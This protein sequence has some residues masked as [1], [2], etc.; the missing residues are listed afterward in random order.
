M[1]GFVKL[2]IIVV[3]SVV[4]GCGD[5]T[6]ETDNK[7]VFIEDGACY[8]ETER[9]KRDFDKG[10]LVYTFY[11]VDEYAHNDRLKAALLKYNID[12]MPLGENCLADSNCYGKYMYSKIV[13]KYGVDFIDS[14]KREINSSSD[15]TSMAN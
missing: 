4:M 3:L 14:L 6:I 9:A 12:Y 5:S 10:I 13:E 8:M 1:K 15:D 7:W 11:S 2:I